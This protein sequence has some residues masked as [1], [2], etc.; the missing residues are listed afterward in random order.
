MASGEVRLYHQDMEMTNFVTNVK[1]DL[2][3][4]SSQKIQTSSIVAGF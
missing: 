1:S 3:T 2:T 4:S